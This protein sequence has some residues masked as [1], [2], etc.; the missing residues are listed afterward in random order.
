[1]ESDR[2]AVRLHPLVREFAASLTPSA[3]VGAF[4]QSAASHLKSAYD[5]PQRVVSEIG[6]RGPSQVIADVTLAESWCEAGSGM[7]RDLE[8]LQ[9]L[10]DRERHNLR[11]EHDATDGATPSS[12][13]QQLHYRAF[14]MQL[15]TLV[16]RFLEVARRPLF[17]PLAVS[18]YEDSAP[19][20]AFVGH[21][22]RVTD[23][24]LSTDG[25]RILSGSDDKSKIIW[26]V[27]TGLPL[28]TFTHGD[29]KVRRVHLSADGQ[30][31]LGGGDSSR[32]SLWDVAT[33]RG[34][35]MFAGL[36]DSPIDDVGVRTVRFH[37]Q[38]PYSVS[39]WLGVTFIGWTG[40]TRTTLHKRKDLDGLIHYVS[41]N[42][43]GIQALIY[44]SAPMFVLD[45]ARQPV[46]AK[47]TIDCY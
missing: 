4:R 37:T 45:G 18:E 19:V 32:L 43:D 22:D 35:T 9:R 3:A 11:A 42:D 40:S 21:T 10:I 31:A 25:R 27:D 26:D 33:G 1:M 2:S 15:D 12:V 30:L 20:R 28:H 17:K 7:A 14:H 6:A 44:L 46:P 38:G 39:A 5:A 47:A 34:T 29:D 8:R 41:L 36:K 23:V 13:P 16:Q 24:A